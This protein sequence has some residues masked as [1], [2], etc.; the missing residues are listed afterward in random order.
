MSEGMLGS[1]FSGR[2]KLFAAEMAKSS[3]TEVQPH[4]PLWA[5]S[6]HSQT[7]LFRE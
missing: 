1:F 4:H 3:W 2:D 6:G 5:K 7:S